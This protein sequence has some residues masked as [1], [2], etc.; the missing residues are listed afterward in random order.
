MMPTHR[1]LKYAAYRAKQRGPVGR[2]TIHHSDIHIQTGHAR[3]ASDATLRLRVVHLCWGV[4]GR[5]WR[6][7]VAQNSWSV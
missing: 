7:R 4:R 5:I 6:G 2:Y 3:F 1:Q